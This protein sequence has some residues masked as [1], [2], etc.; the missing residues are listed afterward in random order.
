MDRLYDR[1]LGADW[2]QHSGEARIWE[3]I[4]NVDDGELWET[5]LSLK[6]RLLE[7]VRRQAIEQAARRGE[8]PEGLQRLGRILS[9]DALTIGFARR[10][11]NQKPADPIPA[12]IE[13]AAEVESQTKQAGG[14]CVA[15]QTGPA[16]G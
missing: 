13:R 8:A 4:E 14:V 16:G 5:H 15:R 12:G 6:S 3:G 1:H 10:F 2:S 11:G 7:F 9:P